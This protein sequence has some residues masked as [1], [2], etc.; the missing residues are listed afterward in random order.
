[1][2]L[3]IEEFRRRIAALETISFETGTADEE[4]T[5]PAAW[6]HDLFPEPQRV[7]AHPIRITNAIIDGD[8]LL[9][10][11][12]APYEIEITGC[13][14]TGRVSFAQ[15]TIERAMDL[16]DCHF[17]KLLSFRFAQLNSDLALERCVCMGTAN[18]NDVVVR[19][20]LQANGT[21]FRGAFE[22]ERANVTSVFFRVARSDDALMPTRFE[23]RVRF[24]DMHAQYFDAEGAQ[25][26]GD[27]NFQRVT[28]EG[29]ALFGAATTD[30]SLNTIATTPTRFGGSTTFRHAHFGP[31]ADFSGA[32]FAAA[33]DFQ[34]ARVDGRFVIEGRLPDPWSF[35]ARFEGEAEFSSMDIGESLWAGGSLFA[36]DCR[37]QWLKVG[38]PANFSFTRDNKSVAATFNGT[39]DLE[40][41]EV[42]G[43]AD[44]R[45]VTFKGEARFARAHIGGVLFLEQVFW[46]EE[47]ARVV[48]EKEANFYRTRVDRDFWCEG[49]A[50]RGDLNC[51]FLS[52]GGVLGFVDFHIDQRWRATITGSVYLNGAQVGDLIADGVRF[53][54]GTTFQGMN[55]DRVTDLEGAQFDG[56]ADFRSMTAGGKLTLEN[57]TVAGDLLLRDARASAFVA[58]RQL[59]A[60]RKFDGRSFTFGRID[61]DVRELLRRQDPYDL[62]LY[63]QAERFVRES[64]HEDLAGMLYLDR[65]RRETR[66]HWQGVIGR[67]GTK[68]FTNLLLAGYGFAQDLLF[69]YGVRPLRLL[70]VSLLVIAFGAWVFSQHDAVRPREKGAQAKQL[71]KSE[72]LGYSLRTFMPIGDLASGSQLLPSDQN[73]PRVTLTYEGYA[74]IQRLLGLM[75]VPLGI[76]AVTGLL[77][78]KR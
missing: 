21:Q 76:A 65:R 9:H 78:R 24:L 39:F 70:V 36:A 34:A 20:L 3:T 30:R 47:R 55:V 31:E 53:A 77:V 2:P 61:G 14:F 62:R 45:S 27:A 26:D 71:T 7:A 22:M 10:Y 44:F 49:S 46:T 23:Q 6:I 32:H 38:G 15:A 43:S 58:P 64:G 73:L 8:L 74:T 12:R 42:A 13:T 16:S 60:G 18:F 33:V 17:P 57:A 56:D 63:E 28:V 72:A 35:P 29:I 66:M 1:V 48:F 54:A 11:A 59:A 41:A 67:E 37:M 50:F 19:R 5:I 4:R 68:R 51:A 52:V 75:L 25:F 40:D 69:R